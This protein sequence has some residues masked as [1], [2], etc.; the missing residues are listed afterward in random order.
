MLVAGIV[1][2][3][4]FYC[5]HCGP[6]S[7]THL[8]HDWLPILVASHLTVASL[9][10]TLATASVTVASSLLPYKRLQYVAFAER[11]GER[12]ERRGEWRIALR[13]TQDKATD[14]ATIS[15]RLDVLPSRPYKAGF[16]D[17]DWLSVGPI[18]LYK[19]NFNRG[20][21]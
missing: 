15:R 18:C 4:N 17:K 21:R 19:L 6:P 10:S 9:L 20:D 7:L 3:F 2:R 13:A 14:L 16:H 11:D 12:L 1:A 5:S 8:K